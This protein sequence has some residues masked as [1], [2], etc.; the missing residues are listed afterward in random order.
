MK[1]LIGLLLF[2]TIFSIQVFGQS[3]SVSLTCGTDVPTQSVVS[4]S[5]SMIR[6][7]FS[8]S[9]TK[10]NP[11]NI[12][13]FR[14]SFGYPVGGLY[15]SGETAETWT[16]ENSP[17]F[18]VQANILLT[19]ACT[20]FMHEFNSSG[21]DLG[22]RASTGTHSIV[23]MQQ[24]SVSS[25]NGEQI[26]VNSSYVNPGTTFDLA[27]NQS[28]SLYPVEANVYDVSGYQMIWGG[29]SQW[30]VNNNFHSSSK[31][32]SYSANVYQNGATILP[33]LSRIY[34]PTFS[35]DFGGG[36][37]NAGGSVVSSGGSV[38]VAN[39]NSI[40]VTAS[41]HTYNGIEYTFSRWQDYTTA[42]P[43]SFTING[44]NSITAY[45]TGR[46][47][48]VSFYFG[49][50]IGDPIKLMWTDNPNSAVTQYYIYRRQK[51]NG[52]YTTP[53]HIGTVNR[54]VGYFEDY[55][56]SLTNTKNYDTWLEYTVLS[57]YTTQGTFS[58]DGWSTIW[59]DVF[60]SM[61]SNDLAMVKAE[62][63]VPSE[64]AIGNYPNPF[65]PTTTISYQ[66]PKDGIVTIK[67]YDIIGR[68]VATLVNE[69]KSAGYYKVD[70][71]AGKMTSGVYICS[72]QS[73]SFSKSIK[74]LL[75]K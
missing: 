70:F 9:G 49:G 67:V 14:L 43:Q 12:W 46:P 3:Y 15:K 45:Y 37:L 71:N 59:G 65:N 48:V 56:F 10:A 61:Q 20:V 34:S 19:H 27:P 73:N 30:T 1:K 58:D 16:D 74:L 63:E 21:T 24:V 75:T 53:V 44:N 40:T 55:D 35:N 42:N 64:Y 22:Q 47:V 31:S 7:T 29:S 2:I 8:F 54:G 62:S 57:Y 25:E 6:I 11:N 69:Q 41:F 26:I 28:L 52:V 32:T 38:P 13:K 5:T 36:T 4:S 18:D 17:Y 66:L 23:P 60:A 72:I 39:G 33:K 50:V 51:P 68:E